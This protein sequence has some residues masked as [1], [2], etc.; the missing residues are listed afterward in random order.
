MLG[1]VTM[2]TSAPPYWHCTLIKIIV[3]EGSSV[4]LVF[5]HDLT[6]DILLENGLSEIR[7]CYHSNIHQNL[8]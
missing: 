3:G 4:L 1:I 8:Y 5:E 2:D 6:M 7:C